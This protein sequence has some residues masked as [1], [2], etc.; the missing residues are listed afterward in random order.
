M[1]LFDVLKNVVNFEVSLLK[2]TFSV[3]K[4]KIINIYH[5]CSIIFLKKGIE[6]GRNNFF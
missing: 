4:K 3:K 2:I 5:F 1:D 6:K